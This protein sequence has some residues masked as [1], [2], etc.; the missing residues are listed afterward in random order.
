MYEIVSPME[1]T[2]ICRY[3]VWCILTCLGLRT[4]GYVRLEQVGI[5]IERLFEISKGHPEKVRA[6]RPID[7]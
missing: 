4:Q 2:N 5:E 7:K 3:T 1:L 6:N